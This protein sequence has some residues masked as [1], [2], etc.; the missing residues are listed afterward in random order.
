[1]RNRPP[2]SASRIAGKTLGESKRGQQYQS[3]VPSVPTSVTVCRSPI[4]P[5][6]A[7]GSGDGQVARPRCPPSRSGHDLPSSTRTNSERHQRASVGL[8]HEHELPLRRRALK[9]LVRA[10]RLTERQALGHDRVDLVLTEQLEQ[11][12]EVLPE[13]LRVAGTS[14]HGTRSPS[15]YGKHL[16]TFAQLLDPVGEHPSAGREQPP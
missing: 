2:W 11:R 8:G 5:C 4:G 6:S 13:P 15:T 3:I 7:M 16:M 12:A 14:T 10:T 1:M 9:Q